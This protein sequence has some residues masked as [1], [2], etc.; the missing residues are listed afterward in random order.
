[1]PEV[2]YSQKAHAISEALGNKTVI[3]FDECDNCNEKFS[4]SL[5]PQIVEYLSLFRT[6]FGV[7][8]KRG[9]T[10]YKGYNF[11]ISKTKDVKIELKDVESR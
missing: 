11:S 8:G 2:T 1:M 3:L 7:K 10:K 6:M 9:D 4:K 5:E